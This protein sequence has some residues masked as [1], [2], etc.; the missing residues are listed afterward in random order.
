MS[1]ERR[2]FIRCPMPESD[3]RAVLRTPDR[4]IVGRLIDTST[5][6]FCVE[7]AGDEGLKGG[8]QFILEVHSG[9]CQVR[10]VHLQD[11]GTPTAH[12]GLERLSDVV[13][14]P[15]C[16]VAKRRSFDIG[17]PKARWETLA[18]LPVAAILIA[19]SIGW[20]L[21]G[22]APSNERQDR[23][24]TWESSSA[25]PAASRFPLAAGAGSRPVTTRQAA[26]RQAAATVP[27]RD[28][29]APG[30]WIEPRGK[31]QL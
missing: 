16:H 21:F 11:A 12:V 29:G 23:H 20:D 31:S 13:S 17:L 6:G 1:A 3:D 22:E 9:S 27:P 8:E 10:V 2:K 7:V 4:Q 26:S 30:R 15:V 25:P 5:G 19:A 24:Q 28:L 14:Q 18:V